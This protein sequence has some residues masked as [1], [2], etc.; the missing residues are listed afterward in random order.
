MLGH[1]PPITSES[2]FQFNGKGSIITPFTIPCRRNIYPISLGCQ[3]YQLPLKTAFSRMFL[4]EQNRKMRTPERVPLNQQIKWLSSTLQKQSYL[5][6]VRFNNNA[7]IFKFCSAY[8]EKFALWLPKF[9]FKFKP[10]FLH[11]ALY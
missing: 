10:Y 2:S 1:P 6:K 3:V 4:Y 9:Q 7:I 8:Y 11:K 5:W